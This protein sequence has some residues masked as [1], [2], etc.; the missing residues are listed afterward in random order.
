MLPTWD[1]NGKLLYLDP[2]SVEEI[3]EWLERA[4]ERWIQTRDRD[5]LLRFPVE[6][7]GVL[8]EIIQRRCEA[9]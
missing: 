5:V 8:A 3:Q 7:R 1:E 2:V 4:A 9:K 6:L